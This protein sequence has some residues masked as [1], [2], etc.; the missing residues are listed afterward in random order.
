MRARELIA[1]ADRLEVH[2]S[3]VDAEDPMWRKR[4]RSE[5]WWASRG[6]RAGKSFR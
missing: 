2:A 4:V 6:R 1:E 5:Q 3:T